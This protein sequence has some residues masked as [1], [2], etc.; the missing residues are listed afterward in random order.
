M[1]QRLAIRI[2][3]SHKLKH[4]RVYYLFTFVFCTFIQSFY[5]FRHMRNIRAQKSSVMRRFHGD[6]S[7]QSPRAALS[8]LGL[9]YRLKQFENFEFTLF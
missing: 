4:H 5:D 6:A 1:L 2:S 7:T 8:E 9:A 3:Y